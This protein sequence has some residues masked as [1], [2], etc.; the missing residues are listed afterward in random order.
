MLLGYK[1][2]NRQSAAAFIAA[3]MTQMLRSHPLPPLDYV[4]WIPMHFIKYWRRGYNQSHLLAKHIAREFNIPAVRLL[5]KRRY[6]KTQ[7]SLDTEMM[8]RRNVT[9]AFMATK[10]T[11]GKRILLIDDVWTT[12]S[13]ARECGWTLAEAGATEIIFAAAF[14]KR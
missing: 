7:S 4:C 10:K 2:Q 6:N 9:G 12:G 8:R 13:T 14:A 1:F 11:A 5:Y 3:E